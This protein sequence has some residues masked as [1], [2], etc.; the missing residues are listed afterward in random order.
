MANA[1]L[2]NFEV[3]E[4][5][6]E[7]RGCDGARAVPVLDSSDLAENEPVGVNGFRESQWF[8]V[9]VRQSTLHPAR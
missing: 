9:P 7:P 1:L 2:C 4:E 3:L 5:K 6:A 8:G